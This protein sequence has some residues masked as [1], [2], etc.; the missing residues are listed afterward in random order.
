MKTI[1]SLVIAFLAV[2]L[3]TPIFRKLSVKFRVLDLPNRR[4]IHRRAMPLLGGEAVF[5][6]VLLGIL[7]NLKE[8]FNLLPILAGATII[9]I[10]GLFDDMKKG[11]LS[12]KVRLLMQFLAV[13][14]VI[15]SGIH[16]SFLPS[17]LWGD[18]G[19]V[20]VTMVWILGITNAYNYLDGMDGLAAGSAVVNSFCFAIILFSTGQST[21]GLLAASLIGACLGFLPYNLKKAKIFLGDAGSTTIGFLL[22]STALLGNWAQDNLVR[23]SIPILVLGVPIFDMIFTTI[24]RIKEEKIKNI[25][26][27]LEYGGKDHFHHYL[28]DL[29]LEPFGAV[30][31]IYFITLSVGISA[32]MVS[33]D[34]AAEALLTLSQ[35]AIIFGVLAVLLVVGKRRHSGWNN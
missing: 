21:A 34:T 33:N 11:S 9:L 22:A 24:M 8:F 35:S 27:W 17:N 2:Y 15:N 14:I 6:G 4:K 25:I 30:L 1:F 12:A 20:I 7:W 31:F 3:T 32:I 10:L 13:M 28:V 19:E 16:V 26:E 29:G 23:L 5:L 18:I